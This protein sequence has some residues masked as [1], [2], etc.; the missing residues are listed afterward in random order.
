MS[1]YP[2]AGSLDRDRLVGSLLLILRIERDLK[3]FLL[4]KN[5]AVFRTLT[6]SQSVFTPAFSMFHDLQAASG[7]L[8]ARRE[9]TFSA[10][11]SG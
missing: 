3:I 9:A 1:S 4:T 7:H 2:S 6:F 11:G 5:M 8:Y 10:T